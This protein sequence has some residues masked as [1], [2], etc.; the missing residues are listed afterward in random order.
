MFEQVTTK[1]FVGTAA[2]GKAYYTKEVSMAGADGISVD[3]TANGSKTGTGTAC[4]F[5]QTS[6]SLENWLFF[7]GGSSMGT[8]PLAAEALLRFTETGTQGAQ[9]VAGGPTNF[10]QYRIAAQYVRIA[11]VQ[12]SGTGSPTGTND[13][14]VG[15]FAIG[16]N[17]KSA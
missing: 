9:V 7:A 6:E 10:Y 1:L 8:V 5:V 14:F 3:V 17:T 13:G 12:L 15:M 4:V 2:P 11:V 16:V